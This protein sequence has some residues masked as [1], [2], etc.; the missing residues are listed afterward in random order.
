MAKVFAE[1]KEK[2]HILSLINYREEIGIVN[3]TKKRE[4]ERENETSTESEYK[5]S[6]MMMMK[7]STCLVISDIQLFTFNIDFYKLIISMLN[8][9][10]NMVGHFQ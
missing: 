1:M 4:G 5:K 9:S 2:W 3:K 10:M 6:T 7:K 8:A